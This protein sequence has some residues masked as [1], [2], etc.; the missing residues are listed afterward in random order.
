[1]SSSSASLSESSES[2]PSWGISGRWRFP[3]RS[4]IAS[5][6]LF[7]EFRSSVPELKGTRELL[8][9]HL[10]LANNILARLTALDRQINEIH[11]NSPC[12]SQI[13]SSPF[14]SR[15]LE[16]PNRI[17]VENGKK[18]VRFHSQLVC[19]LC[20]ILNT[21]FYTRKSIFFNFPISNFGPIL[22]E[23]MAIYGKTF[24]K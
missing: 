4:C 2:A 13:G 24:A 19:C 10:G 16:L 18:S 7:T 8:W 3:R 5:Y 14:Q 21:I 22:N 9:L 17:L 12:T 20:Q 1:M 23:K 15:Q 6:K 11:K